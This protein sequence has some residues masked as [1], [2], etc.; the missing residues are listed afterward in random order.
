MSM[1]E[2]LGNF[3]PAA[4][5]MAGAAN[6]PA[7]NMS[8]LNQSNGTLVEYLI[9]TYVETFVQPVLRHLIL[10][11]QAYETDRVVLGLAAKNS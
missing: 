3:N 8:M 1:D 11:E 4:I 5:M 2:L 10:L 6:A 9:R 7:R